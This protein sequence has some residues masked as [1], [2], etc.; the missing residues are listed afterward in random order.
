MNSK[1]QAGFAQTEITPKRASVP[2]G[3]YGATE[4]RLSGSVLD[5]LYARAIALSDGEETCLYVCLDL[6][7]IPE[8]S[9]ARCRKAINEATGLRED[10]I[11]FGANHTHAGPDLRSP[12]PNAVQYREV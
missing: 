5:P 3:G 2:L 9:V 11:F 1:L 12:L 8:D 7:G 10:R 6:L 4:Y